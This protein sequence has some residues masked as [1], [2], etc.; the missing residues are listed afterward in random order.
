MYRKKR[1]GAGV[2]GAADAIDGRV[3]SAQQIWLRQ[4]R[5]A[6]K[7]IS[8]QV[9]GIGDIEGSIVIVITGIIARSRSTPG[10]EHCQVEDGIGQVSSGIAVAIAALKRSGGGDQDGEFVHA[11]GTD[12]TEGEIIDLVENPEAPVKSKP[13]TDAT[14][15]G[16]G[17]A[18]G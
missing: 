2:V 17:T 14:A 3:G 11:V 18:L 8:Q 15:R 16:D 1:S 13:T 4:F 10:E 7:E 12:W 5:P 6:I 9:D